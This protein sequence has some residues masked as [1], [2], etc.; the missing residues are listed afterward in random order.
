MPLKH[1]AVLA[2]IAEFERELTVERIRSGL[3]RPKHG[4]R[5]WDG[6]RATAQIGPASTQGAGPHRPGAELSPGRAR[7]GA[8]QKHGGWDREAESGARISRSLTHFMFTV[9]PLSVNPNSVLWRHPHSAGRRRA[10][11]VGGTG[12]G[13]IGLATLLRDLAKEAAW[14]ARRERIRQASAVIG[15]H[16]AVSEEGR[17]FY[18]EWGTPRADAG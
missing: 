15:R 4:A 12:P 2:G 14:D 17:R 3:R 8:E 13:G 7:A 9:R 5:S 16:V 6:S 18:E 1:N 10:G 11:G